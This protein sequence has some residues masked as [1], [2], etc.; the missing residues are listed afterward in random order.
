MS[1]RAAEDMGLSSGGL[2]LE[3]TR[4]LH[5]DVFRL[6][7][8]QRR[9]LCP[10]VRQ[11]QGRNLLVEFL[12]Q[13]VDIVLVALLLLLV[14]KEVKLPQDLVCE[15]ARH[16][17]RGMACGAAQIEQASRCKHD[18]A[19][20]VREDEAVDL[21]L[22]VL[23]LDAWAILELCHLNLVV[24]VA[25]VADD[26]IVLHLLHVLQCDDLEVARGGGEDV[27]LAHHGI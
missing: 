1:V 21:R 12:R 8:R 9:E 4:S 11:V 18:D 15:G 3:R 19:M 24:E 27:D 5:S 7:L 25:N 10:E 13:Q 14:C 23:N 22:D 26:S 6:L 17:E 2:R 20:A 16:H